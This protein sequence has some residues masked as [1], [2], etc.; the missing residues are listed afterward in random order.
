MAEGEEC[1]DKLSALGGQDASTS[2]GGDGEK[3][4]AITSKCLSCKPVFTR[5]P[6]ESGA[7]ETAVFLPPH[8]TPEAWCVGVFDARCLTWW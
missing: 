4:L 3:H 6:T 7:V 8:E 5:D 2:K 1:K